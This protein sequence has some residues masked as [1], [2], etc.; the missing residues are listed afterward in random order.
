MHSEY[1]NILKLLDFSNKGYDYFRRWYIDGRLY[2]HNIIDNERPE[3]GIVELRGIDPTKIT[4]V[5]KV[6]KE[7]KTIDGKQIYVVKNIDEHFIY[8]DLGIFLC[9]DTPSIACLIDQKNS[10]SSTRN[11]K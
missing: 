11:V 8:V 3:K 5:R 10:P 6:E 9:A 2:F 1:K 4:K 7:L